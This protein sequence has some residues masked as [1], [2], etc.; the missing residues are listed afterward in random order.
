MH[1]CVYLT[2][3]TFACA[4]SAS[5]AT[6]QHTL[7]VFADGRDELRIANGALRVEHGSW[8]APSNLTV[9]G[10]AHPL[11]FSGSTSQAIPVPITGDYWARRTAGRDGAY[12][13]QRADGFALAVVD[14]PNGGDTYSFDLYDAPVTGT[15][16]WMR[17]RAAG[18]TPGRMSFPGVAGYVPTA[19]GSVTNFS[20]TI[21]GTV[22][23]M[24]A[25]GALVMRHISWPNPPSS[26]AVNGVS[27]PVTWNNLLSS[28]IPVTLPDQ[29]QFNQTGGRVVLYPVETPVGLLVGAA[30][31][32][33]GSNGYTFSITAVPEPTLGAATLFSAAA[34]LMRRRR[35]FRL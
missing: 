23:L 3:L 21:D 33:L 6:R 32:L 20:L 29:F 11:V 27:H 19:A 5:A 24:F 15:V 18:G 9:D 2:V 28:P 35:R 34:M 31:E 7:S 22:D 30:D 25:D 12:G 10:V 1:Q 8:G 17:V 26:V 14:N 4:G 16:E 13:V